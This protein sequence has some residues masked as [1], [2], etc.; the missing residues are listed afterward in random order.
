MTS[1]DTLCITLHESHYFDGYY[2]MSLLTGKRFRSKKCNQ[3]SL[4]H[5]TIDKVNLMEENKHQPILLKKLP[6]SKWT[7]GLLN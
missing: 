7:P 3:L 1:R 6:N 4:D 5:A 2:F